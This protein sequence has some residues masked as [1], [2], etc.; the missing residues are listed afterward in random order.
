MLR[1]DS[2]STE[3]TNGRDRR[4]GGTNV[5]LKEFFTD[6]VC[7]WMLALIVISLVGMLFLDLFGDE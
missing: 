6:P 5:S 7:Q 4:D 3:P 1:R 2:L